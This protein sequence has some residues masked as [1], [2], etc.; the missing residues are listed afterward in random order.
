MLSYSYRLPD[1]TSGLRPRRITRDLMRL[2]RSLARE[3][4]GD[5]RALYLSDQ[6]VAYERRSLAGGVRVVLNNSSEPARLPAHFCTGEVL[7]LV[8]L[9]QAPDVRLPPNSGFVGRYALT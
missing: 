2:R 7:A 4:Y 8:E 6:L 1:K 5:A 9:E 3:G